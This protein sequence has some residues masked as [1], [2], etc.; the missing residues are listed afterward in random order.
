MKFCTNCKVKVNDANE[1]CPL[2]GSYLDRTVT[3]DAANQKIQQYVSNPPLKVEGRT[4]N[5]LKKRMFWFAAIIFI[6]CAVAN[7][8][9]TPRGTFWTEGYY[10]CGYVLFGL[11]AAYFVTTVSVYRRRRLYSVIGLGCIVAAITVL[12]LETTY[13][14]SVAKNLSRVIYSMEFIIPA[15]A[16]ATIIAT[17]VLV[18]V[19]RGKYKYYFISL[20]G[21]TAV[22]I[23]PQLVVWIAKPDYGANWWLIFSAFF[24]GIVNLL[25][26]IVAFWRDFKN[27]MLRKFSI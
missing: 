15:I 23:V 26:M 18:I 2:C 25:V 9:T 1:Y 7:F 16:I 4:K 3:D 21:S 5:Y 27:E 6:V 24:F 17:D 11:F 8:M 22:A 13:S 19:D 12:G 20:L 10:W 14:L